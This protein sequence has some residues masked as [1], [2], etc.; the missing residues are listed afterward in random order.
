[1]GQYED[2]L[3]RER[4]TF[5]HRIK[6]SIHDRAA[7]FSP[8]AALTGY[9]AVISEAGR[10]TDSR[11]ELTEGEKY[12][13]DEILQEIQSKLETCPRVSLECFVDDGRK[14]GGRY[15]RIT[16]RVK[17]VD[18]VGKAI[19]LQEGSVISVDRILDITLEAK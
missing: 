6:M 8:F 7:Q 3:Y 18:Q 10:L 5:P 12:R 2:I 11:R 14:E 9:D 19:V 16:G 17:A 4:P 13:L 15:V 1:M